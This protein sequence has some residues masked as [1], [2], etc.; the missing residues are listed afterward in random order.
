MQSIGPLTVATDLVCLFARSLGHTL[1]LYTFRHDQYGQLSTRLQGSIW[2]LTRVGRHDPCTAVCIEP[3]QL[4]LAWFCLL[5]IG[6]A[7]LD[8][9]RN[10]GVAGFVCGNWWQC[11]RTDEPG[12]CIHSMHPASHPSG[13]VERLLLITTTSTAHSSLLIITGSGCEWRWP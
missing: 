9:A 12:R 1:G 11:L 13:S 5:I 6:S 7:H 10:G 2:G 3:V 8:H 4:V